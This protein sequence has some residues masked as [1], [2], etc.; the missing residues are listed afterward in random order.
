MSAFLTPVADHLPAATVLV[1]LLVAASCWLLPARVRTPYAIAGHG[2]SLVLAALVA[3]A[4]AGIGEVGS[5]MGGWEAPLGIAVRADGISAVFLLLGAIVLL[6][7]AV[8]AAALGG[9]SP[10]LWPLLAM[11]QAGLAAVMV[12]AD[13]FNAYIGLELVGIAAVGLVALGGVGAATAALR[14]LIVAV[15]GSL[16]FLVAVGVVYGVTGSLDM[17]L[18]GQAWASADVPAAIPLGLAAIGLALK[19]A[20]FPMHGWLPPAHANAS[21][22]AS[23]VLSALVVKAPLIVLLRLWFEVTGP[24]RLT[25]IVLGVLGAGAV[26]WGG[27]LALTQRRLKRIVAYS[28]VAQVGY[29]FLLFPL[30]LATVAEPVRQAALAAVITLAVAHGLAKSALFLVAGTIKARCGTDEIDD[31]PGLAAA[32]PPMILAFA[33][34]AISIIGLPIS[35]GF[36]GKWQLLT[37]SADA[38]AWWIIPVVLVGTVLSAGYLLRPLA[39]SLRE[40]RDEIRAPAPGWR[41]AV[42]PMLLVIAGFALGI[43]SVWLVELS[44]V[45]WQGA[46]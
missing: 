22:A 11:L 19:C 26:L 45:G 40:P 42:A 17:A 8:H 23:P 10:T 29:L 9:Q 41:V 18:A 7:V 20:L 27:L 43:S 32:W 33:G 2:V 28:T 13:L 46:P 25:G 35:A 24:D 37:A 6:A 3:W 4:V 34:A 39:A 16:L 14:Y 12:A 21:S 36:V 30:T 31:L 5:A 44:L 38:G 15:L 1:P